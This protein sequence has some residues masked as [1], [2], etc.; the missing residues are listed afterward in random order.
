MANISV[1]NEINFSL[2]DEEYE[3]LNKALNILKPIAHKLWINDNE[4]T[5]LYDY[6]SF[7]C[8]CV[9]NLVKLADRKVRV[10]KWKN[11]RVAEST[12]VEVYSR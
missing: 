3:I 1:H 12:F 9:E 7:G 10:E 4:E 5:E 6:A 8:E 2:E 11:K